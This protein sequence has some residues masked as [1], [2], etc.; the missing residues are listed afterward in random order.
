LL[1]A[2]PDSDPS[3]RGVGL[4][5][6]A[7]NVT[8]ATQVALEGKSLAFH[9][10][11]RE[12]LRGAPVIS[13]IH[14]AEPEV[15][16]AATIAYVVPLVGPDQKPI[17][18]LALWVKATALWDIA[19]SSNLLAGPGSFAVLFDQEGVRIAHTYSRDI[20]FHPGGALDPKVLEEFV[21][22]ERF[23]TSTRKL[24]MDVRPFPEQFERARA[25]SP[26]RDVFRGFAPVN[27]TWNYGVGRRFETTPWTMF[28]MVPEASLNAEI[29]GMTRRK[30]LFATAII[31]LALATG[32]LFAR[33][34]LQPVSSL[35]TATGL[36]ASGVLDARVGA[37]RRDEIGQLG[38]SFDAMADRIQAQAKA[39]QQ[40][41]EELEVRVQERTAELARNA[42]ALRESEESLATTLNS[43]GD[44]VIATDTDGRVTRMNPVAEQLTG[45]SRAEAQGKA[46]ND[47]FRILNEDT[48]ELVEGPVERVLRDGVVVELAN[49]T[50]LVSRNGGQRRAD[51]G[52]ARRL[53]GRGVGV[54]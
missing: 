54:S 13:N 34:I 5:D 29:S 39:L 24:L 1:Q 18:L 50:V 38:A 51:S 12:A 16:R 22:E 41:N 14:L 43:I 33:A 23:G 9:A 37:I 46:L 15:G 26:N 42:Q 2:Q 49:H 11:V 32:L 28:Y 17:A 45:W 8:V 48:N 10:Y 31:L 7:G 27:K 30:L 52:R 44:A 3:V 20:V 47:V 25:K 36:L 6:L 21:A 4:L 53:A 35:A 19:R 40:T